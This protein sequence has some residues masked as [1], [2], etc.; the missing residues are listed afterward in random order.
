MIEVEE[1]KTEKEKPT[2]TDV[3]I[4]YE[5]LKKPMIALRSLLLAECKRLENEGVDTTGMRIYIERD[6]IL[7]SIGNQCLRYEEREC[8]FTINLYS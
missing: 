6:E 4:V 1:I 3:R 7:L 2:E 8:A 5:R